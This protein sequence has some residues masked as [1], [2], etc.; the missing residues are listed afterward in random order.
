M[1]DEKGQTAEEKKGREAA[2]EAS[3][4]DKLTDRVRHNEAFCLRSHYKGISVSSPSYTVTNQP[5]FP[6]PHVS[7]QYM[8]VEEKE[9]DANKVQQAMSSFA[10]PE[11]TGDQKKRRVVPVS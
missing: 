4:L 7:N 2:E 8:Q 11:K 9:L 3:A 6:L 1:S 5:I 10:S